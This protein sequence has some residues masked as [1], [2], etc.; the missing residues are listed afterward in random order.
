MRPKRGD[1]SVR[2]SARARSP[3]RAYDPSHGAV[4]REALDVARYNTGMTTKLEALAFAAR[5]DRLVYFLGDGESGKR[6]I[7]PHLRCPRSRARGGAIRRACS[8]TAPREQFVRLRIHAAHI[9]LALAQKAMGSAIYSTR[10]LPVRVSSSA[11]RTAR[12]SRAHARPVRTGARAARRS[13]TYAHRQFRRDYGKTDCQIPGC[14]FWTYC[15]DFSHRDRPSVET[16]LHPHEVDARLYVACHDCT[17]DRG[18]TSPTRQQRAWRFTQPSLGASRI[19]IGNS[20]PYAAT[21]AT[22]PHEN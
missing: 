20:R 17:L 5:L 2:K 4:T 16:S 14:V 10:P 21:T 19:G 22:L 8:W 13:P 11:T 1:G 6:N 9:S 7:D 12:R 18:S 3:R 15:N